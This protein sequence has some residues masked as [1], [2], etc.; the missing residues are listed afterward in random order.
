MEIRTEK[1]I[2]DE[3]SAM[4]DRAYIRPTSGDERISA[5]QKFTYNNEKQ[6]FDID[7]L[8][9]KL[10]A[11]ASAKMNNKEYQELQQKIYLK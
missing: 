8:R 3:Y 10:R 1:E 11:I 6:R 2:A 5:C 4:Y 9:D 7:H